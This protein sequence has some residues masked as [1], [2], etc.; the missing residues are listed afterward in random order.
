MPTSAMADKLV[1]AVEVGAISEQEAIEFLVA[2][3]RGDKEAI[4]RLK[5]RYGQADK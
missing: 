1:E 2:F 5:E 4:E 3:N